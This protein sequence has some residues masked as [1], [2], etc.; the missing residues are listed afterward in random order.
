MPCISVPHIG[1]P[2]I[3]LT[4]PSI[5]LPPIPLPGIS[6]CCTFQLPPI[7]MSAINTIIAAAI[8][9]LPGVGKLLGPVLSVLTKFIAIVNKLLDKIQF[10]CPL[11]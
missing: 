4:L 1:L 2:D 10:S 8:A 7:D 6:V 3:G 5:A 9:L 11:N